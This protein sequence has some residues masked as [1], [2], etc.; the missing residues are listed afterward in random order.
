M[1][2]ALESAAAVLVVGFTR[3]D[4]PFAGGT[5]VPFP[6]AIFAGL[7]TDPAGGLVLDAT[8]PPDVPAGFE[9]YYQFWIF[10]PAGPAGLSASNGLLSVTP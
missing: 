10:D 6:D 4:A 3:L 5:L 7:V 1:T 2:G 8:W 9:T